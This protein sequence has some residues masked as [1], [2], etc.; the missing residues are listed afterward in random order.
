MMGCPV[1]NRDRITCVA[2]KI[3][4]KKRWNREEQERK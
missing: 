1:P 4:T 3:D 2:R